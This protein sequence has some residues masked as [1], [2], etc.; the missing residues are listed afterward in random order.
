MKK[1]AFKMG[2]EKR[3]ANENRQVE[4]ARHPRPENI[5]SSFLRILRTA[6]VRRTGRKN[7]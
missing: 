2:E 1:D 3:I 4:A 7:A 5:H 6:E